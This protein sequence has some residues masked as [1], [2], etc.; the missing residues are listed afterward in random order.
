MTQARKSSYSS[1]DQFP[2]QFKFQ[3]RNLLVQNVPVSQI[4]DSVPTHWLWPQNLEIWQRTQN[5]TAF[6]LINW[7]NPQFLAERVKRTTRSAKEKEHRSPLEKY[8][9]S[10]TG[11]SPDRPS[12]RRRTPHTMSFSSKTP[13]RPLAMDARAMYE[14]RQQNHRLL[15]RTIFFFIIKSFVCTRIAVRPKLGLG[16]V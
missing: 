2:T 4:V 11:L 6:L 15:L 5:H 13:R 16:R 1:A 3:A 14:I 9:P 12:R 7:Y 8:Q 10:E